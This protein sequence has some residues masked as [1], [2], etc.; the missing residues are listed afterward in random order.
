M[1]SP[2]TESL[3]LLRVK[4]TPFRLPIISG[5][6]PG[7]DRSNIQFRP[8]A[9]GRG[10]AF[11]L[12]ELLVVIAVIAILAAL[13]LPGLQGAKLRAQQVSCLSN[14]RQ[15]AVAR[16]IYADDFGPFD[17]PEALLSQAFSHL[18]SY[19][20]TPGVLLCA[21]AAVT[22][23]Q[24]PPFYDGIWPGAADQAWSAPTLNYP[25]PMVGRMVGSY[26][27]NLN[28]AQ[29]HPGVP[30]RWIGKNIPAHP[31]QTPTFAD[32]VTPVV[33]AVVAVP[34]PANLYNPMAPPG[35]IAMSGLMIARHGSRPA[36]AAPRNIDISKPLPGII[37]LALY[38]GHVEKSPLENLWNYYWN[39]DWW[40]PGRRP[41]L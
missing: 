25:N 26:A 3:W 10:M 33:Y 21:S 14:L 29:S 12:I 30:E 35:G 24:S 31:S 7:M 39:A 4:V 20:V 1:I 23:S 18:N 19:G 34:P 36:S 28:L 38:D 32:A 17:I 13:L 6:C 2:L 40:V 11:T 9:F 5:R 15:M 16:Q 41:G 22:N 8:I 27:F 37:D